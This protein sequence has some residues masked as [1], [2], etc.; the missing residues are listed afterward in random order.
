MQRRR[1]TAMRHKKFMG[2]C[3]FLSQVMETGGAEAAPL[4]QKKKASRGRIT[5]MPS[6]YSDVIPD[7]GRSSI[8]RS[9]VPGEMHCVDD[10]RGHF[11]S[12]AGTNNDAEA[13]HRIVYADCWTSWT[14]SVP[15]WMGGSAAP[16]KIKISMDAAVRCIAAG[17][18]DRC[19]K[20]L[21][22]SA[23][24]AGAFGLCFV[25]LSPFISLIKLK[26]LSPL[27]DMDFKKD[28]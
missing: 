24:V 12:S 17:L 26:T 15:L 2:A 20:R 22:V 27:S 25:S 18:N 16:D 28:N 21:K 19:R 3:V 4:R 6:C 9:T 11:L 13:R 5:L 8:I 10:S 1:D 14:K 23:N 7:A